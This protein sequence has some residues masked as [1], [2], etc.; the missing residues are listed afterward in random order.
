[1]TAPVIPLDPRAQ[2]VMTKFVTILDQINRLGVHGFAR[3]LDTATPADMTELLSAADTMQRH[4]D[5]VKPK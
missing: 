2:V 1:M 4:I 3:V 5:R